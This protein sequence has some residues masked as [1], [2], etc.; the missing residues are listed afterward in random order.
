MS[1]D[2]TG[3]A[4]SAKAARTGA[5]LAGIVDDVLAEA[6]MAW[7]Y[8]ISIAD[9]ASPVL[10]TGHV[11]HRHDFGLGPVE[12]GLRTRLAWAVPKAEV[13]AR[14]PWHISG[15]LLGLDVAL[16]SL[17]R[18]NGERVIDPPTLSA[19][20]REA[21]AVSVALLDPLALRD[22]DR[23]AIVDAV[24]RGRNR[25]ALLAEDTSGF[26]RITTEIQMEGMRR[27]ALQWT[28]AN[29]P[30]RLG[31]L[32]SLTELLYLG[33]GPVAAL[34]PWGTSAMAWSGCLCTRLAP[35]RLWRLLSG[36]PQLGLMAATVPDLN[37]HVA[38]MLRELH[39]PAAVAKVILE[40]A[41]QDFIDEVRPTDFNDW[42]TL[43]RTA[44]TFSRERIEDYVATAT[45][46]GPLVPEATNAAVQP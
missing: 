35:P 9:P 45:A 25:V 21:F 43:I 26:D 18:V 5:A 38:M 37:L 11:T 27:R 13:L 40:A 42:L 24:A 1:W 16:S 14:I 19:N 17:R 30:Q 46:V 7:A 3:A 44:R 8:A 6:L 29:E 23:D 34:N 15:S 31:S 20:E 41:M 36:R 28:I 12:R 33:D 2:E 39:L 32:F 22:E 4:D 10:L